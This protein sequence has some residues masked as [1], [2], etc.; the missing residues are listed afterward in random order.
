[1]IWRQ[2]DQL[3]TFGVITTHRRR[4]FMVALGKKEND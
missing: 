2:E 1:M 4:N 3:E